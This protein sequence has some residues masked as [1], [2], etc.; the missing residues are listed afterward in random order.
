[1]APKKDA[2]SGKSKAVA[3]DE[4]ASMRQDSLAKLALEKSR[5][6]SEAQLDRVRHMVATD[7]NEWG[8]MELKPAHSRGKLG[9]TFYPVFWHTLFAGLVPPLSDFF[10]AILETYQIRLLHLQPNSVLILA[11]FANLCEAYLGVR[12]SVALFRHF[13]AI[14]IT[15]RGESSGCVS[16]RISDNMSGCYIPIAWAGDKPVTSV[17]K[18]VDDF[19]KRWLFVDACKES[20]RFAVPD[21]PPA[22][23]GSWARASPW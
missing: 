12:P 23:R 5:V 6:T 10:E 8:A 7:F 3:E 18:K 4:S 19:R 20:P 14:R 13:Y 15:A 11:I 21:A 22:K 1:M 9:A 17:T 16:F 2:A